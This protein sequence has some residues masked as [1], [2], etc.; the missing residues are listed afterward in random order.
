MIYLIILVLQKQLV[1]S[2]YKNSVSV[3]IKNCIACILAKIKVGLREEELHPVPPGKRPF[4]VIHID[5]LGPF[6]TTP[7]KTTYLLN[8]VDTFTNII[9]VEL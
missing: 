4:E 3:H 1:R 6:P 9:Y 7:R 5:H 2:S 8:I